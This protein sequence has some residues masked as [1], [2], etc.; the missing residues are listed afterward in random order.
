MTLKWTN[1]R[2]IWAWISIGMFFAGLISAGAVTFKKVDNN[3]NQIKYLKE[4]QEKDHEIL[5]R[6]D[7]NIKGI[8]EDIGELKGR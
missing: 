8:K 7:E 6:I 4:K 2:I 1:G 3:V 5:I